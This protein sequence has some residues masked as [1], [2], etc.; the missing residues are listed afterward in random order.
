MSAPVGP[1]L[2]L[3]AL[4]GGPPARTTP[5]AHHLRAETTCADATQRSSHG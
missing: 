4:N 2:A 3:H 5:R 1:A